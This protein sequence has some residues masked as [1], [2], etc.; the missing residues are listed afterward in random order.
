MPGSFKW[1]LSFRFSCQN[2]VCTSP[3]P[4]VCQMLC[5]FHS[6]SFDHPNNIW[7]GLQIMKLLTLQSPVTSP[8]LAPLSFS[9]PYSCCSLNVRDVS[10][11]PL[12]KIGNIIVLYIL[13]V[14]FFGSKCDDKRFWTESHKLFH[15]KKKHTTDGRMLTI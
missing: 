14:T 1:S 9:A 15:R 12:Q 8:L 5:P 4:H 3:F 2:P 7:C 13:I 10:F 6:Y 11:T